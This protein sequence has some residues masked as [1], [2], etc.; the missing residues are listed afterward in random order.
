MLVAVAAIVVNLAIEHFVSRQAFFSEQKLFLN[1]VRH[2]P[3]YDLNLHLFYENWA[4]FLVKLNHKRIFNEFRGQV[5][6]VDDVGVVQSV[7]W[8]VYLLFARCYVD[9][10]GQGPQL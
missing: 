10:R 7:H 3:I 4:V 6:L 2:H 1:V 9:S 5:T 8:D